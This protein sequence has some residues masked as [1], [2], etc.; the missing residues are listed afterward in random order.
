MLAYCRNTVTAH[1]TQRKT[2]RISSKENIPDMEVDVGDPQ[3]IDPDRSSVDMV[4]D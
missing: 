1:I 4:V 3:V 2:E